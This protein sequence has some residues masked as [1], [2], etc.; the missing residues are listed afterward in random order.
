MNL[1][2]LFI[3]NFKTYEAGVNAEV[4]TASPVV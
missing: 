1:A 3:K 4:R 2:G